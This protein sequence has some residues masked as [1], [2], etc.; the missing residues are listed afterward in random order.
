[1][2]DRDRMRGRNAPPALSQWWLR[3]RRGSRVLLS[4]PLFRPDAQHSAT[5]HDSSAAGAGAV[6]RIDLCARSS[7]PACCADHCCCGGATLLRHPSPTA[8]AA[9]H[10]R[11]TPLPLF[12]PAPPPALA[13]MSTASSQR[14]PYV[15]PTAAQPA[16]TAAHTP[17]AAVTAGAPSS[18]QSQ[19]T[20]PAGNH[21]SQQQAAANNGTQ[22]AAAAAAAASHSRQPSQAAAAAAA[23]AAAAAASSSS[24]SSSTYSA[25]PADR[26]QLELSDRAHYKT[27]ILSHGVFEVESKYIMKEMIGQGAYGVVCSAFDLKAQKLVAIKKIENVF[28]HRSLAKRTLRELKI[29]R[30][31]VHENILGIERVVRPHASNFNN[32][33]FVS[34]LMETDLACVIRSPQELTEEHWYTHNQ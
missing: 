5:Q 6:I 29:V 18:S 13:A 12:P 9:S 21:T 23:P 25:L 27:F 10:P 14:K 17:A 7:L 34:E 2:C 20:R 19:A 24:S 31:L 33:Y 4:T 1:M 26:P 11:I 28:D 3:Q 30:A 8:T 22:T 32:I 15:P 16:P